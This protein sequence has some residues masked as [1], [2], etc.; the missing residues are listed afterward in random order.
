MEVNLAKLLSLCYNSI[1][2]RLPSDQA[3]GGGP[4]NT[5]SLIGQW[6]KVATE[7]EAN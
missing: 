6:P 2:L 1:E 4:A 3:G 7:I 5:A